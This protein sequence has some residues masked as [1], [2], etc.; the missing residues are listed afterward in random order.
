MYGKIKVNVLRVWKNIIC[1]GC[2][3]DKFFVIVFI[4]VNDSIV[5]RM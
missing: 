5:I 1:M 2:K 3:F 4:M